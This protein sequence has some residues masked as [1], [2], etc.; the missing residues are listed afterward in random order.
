VPRVSIQRTGMFPGD[1]PRMS[2][3]THS[4]YFDK[5]KFPD[6]TMFGLQQPESFPDFFRAPLK[7]VPGIRSIERLPNS[8][9]NDPSYHFSGPLLIED[10]LVGELSQSKDNQSEDFEPRGFRNLELLK[11]FIDSQSKRKLAYLTFGLV[12]K[13][14]D[15]IFACIS[16]LLA[17]G[18]AVVSNVKVSGLTKQQQELYY[19]A[20]YLPMN[21]VCLRADLVVHHCGSATYHYPLIHGVPS[22]TIGTKCYDRDN[23]AAR[24]QELGASV[25][26]PAPDECDHFVDLFQRSVA[27]YFNDSEAFLQEA[28]RRVNELRVEIEKTSSCF[29]F[30]ELLHEAAESTK[31]YG[32]QEAQ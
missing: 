13:P 23:V 27:R 7:I 31:K 20:S 19:Y 32:N 11:A 1:G 4:I 14:G 9:E 10:Y 26:L 30:V 28:K 12:A 29:N 3:H 21:F 25:Y 24:L 15:A 2:G 16:Y 17:N 6:V 8:L 18:I 5:E 22:I